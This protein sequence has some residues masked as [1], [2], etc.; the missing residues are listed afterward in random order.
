MADVV[1][2]E[3]A[4]YKAVELP[5]G[6]LDDLAQLANLS[7]ETLLHEIEVRYAADKIYVR[8]QRQAQIARKTEGY[9]GGLAR[10]KRKK[11]RRFMSAG[12]VGV[13][14][15]P[16]QTSMHSLVF[17]ILAALCYS[18]FGICLERSLKGHRNGAIGF[19]EEE[20]KQERERDAKES[21][22]GGRLDRIG[23]KT[24]DD[25]G[26]RRHGHEHQLV[27]N[28]LLGLVFYTGDKM[29]GGVAT[30]CRHRARR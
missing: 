30:D 16:Y 2:D 11:R 19:E 21:V 23:S 20:R 25:C 28:F 5:E 4:M 22:L 10:G 9:C 24:R 13:R 8:R 27:F 18:R 15:I 12:L 26:W 3:E 6:E 7:A 17:V 1:E 29:E 14:S